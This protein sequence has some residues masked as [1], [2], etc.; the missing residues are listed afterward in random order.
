[1]YTV[2]VKG[3]GVINF[4][5]SPTRIPAEFHKVSQKELKLLTVLCRH[6]GA[7]LEIMEAESERLLSIAEKLNN[8]KISEKDLDLDNA[9]VKI[10]DLF[11][12]NDV[13]G[14]LLNSLE[15]DGDE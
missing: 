6:Q 2:K 11:K 8:V 3:F 7:D 12:S 15:K 13:M 10:E 14:E 5:N 9:E 4:R 1:M